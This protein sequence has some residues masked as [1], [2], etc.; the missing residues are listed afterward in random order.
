MKPYCQNSTV[1]IKFYYCIPLGLGGAMFSSTPKYS[2][3]E[4]SSS[5]TALSSCEHRE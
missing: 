1:Y 3:S 5:V 2:S 4:P